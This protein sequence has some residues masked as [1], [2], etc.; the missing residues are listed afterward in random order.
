MFRQDFPG[1]A[2]GKEPTCQGRRLKRCG[3]DPWVR[4]I[5][6]RRHG[7]PFQDFCLETLMDRGAWQDTVHRVAKSQT[8]T[9]CLGIGDSVEQ[10]SR[11]FQDLMSDDMRWI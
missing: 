5:P 1:G 7:K 4:K 3:F 2:R 10:E 6:W 8:H 9:L 11:N